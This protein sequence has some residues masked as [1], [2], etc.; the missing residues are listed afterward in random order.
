MKITNKQVIMLFEIAKDTIKF[1]L[2]GMFSFDHKS[3]AELVN[4]ILNQQSNQ[5]KELKEEK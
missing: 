4:Q 2:K 3:R 1:D 5:L